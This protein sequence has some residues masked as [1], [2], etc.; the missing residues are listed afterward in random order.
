MPLTNNRAE[1][2]EKV[3]INLAMKNF[4]SDDA[5]DVQVSIDTY[6]SFINLIDASAVYDTI[7]SDEIVMKENG[8]LIELADNIP[9]QRE[10]MFNITATDTSDSSWTSEFSITSFAP[11]LTPKKLVVMDEETGNGNGRLDPGESAIIK[12]I[13][14]NTGHCIAYDVTASLEVASTVSNMPSAS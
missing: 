13:T 14:A 11:N 4:G 12:I 7:H 1:Y 10:I 2:D 5:N 3:F 8:F 9:D 6:D